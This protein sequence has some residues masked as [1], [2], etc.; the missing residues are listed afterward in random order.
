MTTEQKGYT[1]C[2]PGILMPSTRLRGTFV[3]G[4][5]TGAPIGAAFNGRSVP[6][7]FLIC[8]GDT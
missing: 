2:G 3:F 8:V 1:L 7:S 4:R 5:R 6:I